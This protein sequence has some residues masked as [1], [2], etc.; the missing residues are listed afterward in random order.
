MDFTC[1][2]CQGTERISIH[3]VLSGHVPLIASLFGI[4]MLYLHILA[5][6]NDI[7]VLNEAVKHSDTSIS[8]LGKE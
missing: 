5:M 8:L 7:G 4:P 2:L 6:V 3:L 1:I